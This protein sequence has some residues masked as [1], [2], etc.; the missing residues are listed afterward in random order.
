VKQLF[1][2]IN[3]VAGVKCISFT[4]K[5]KKLQFNSDT[6]KPFNVEQNQP[7]IEISAIV[8]FQLHQF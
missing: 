2:M 3:V 5:T 6:F 1:L 7:R 4:K 8:Y